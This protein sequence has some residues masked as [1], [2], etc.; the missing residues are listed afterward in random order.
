MLKDI[1]L[2]IL[3]AVCLY[4][5]LRF[6]KIY[7]VVLVPVAIFAIVAA[8]YSGSGAGIE[9]VKGLL[10]GIGLML[11]PFALGGMGAGDVKLMGVVGALKGPQFVFTAF[12]AAAIAGGIMALIAMLRAGRLKQGLLSVWYSFLSLIGIIPKINLLGT[13]DDA[14]EGWSIPYGAAITIGT[15]ASYF[16]LR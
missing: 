6:K 4:T 15:L 1:I 8:F 16:M 12:L 5:D 13:L 3:L 10:L 14:H 7:N 2:V 11:I 9:S